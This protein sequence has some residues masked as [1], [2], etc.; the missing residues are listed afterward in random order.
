MRLKCPHCGS[1]SSVRKSERASSLSG[2]AIYKCSNDVEC[3]FTF[4]AVFEIVG[5]IRPPR[6]RNAAIV[7]PVLKTNA[8]WAKERSLLAPQE[9]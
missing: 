5:E 4:K 7:L 8:Q 1:Y 2:T 9:A 3:G 6:I